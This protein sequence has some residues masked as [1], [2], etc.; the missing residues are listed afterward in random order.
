M[1]SG[2]YAINICAALNYNLVYMACHYL[3]GAYSVQEMP[4]LRC[5]VKRCQQ[6]ILKRN[7][8]RRNKLDYSRIRLNRLLL[9]YIYFFIT[10]RCLK[11]MPRLLLLLLLEAQN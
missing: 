5:Y 9:L 11:S 10:D 8:R 7:K 3:E 1:P 6:E 4:T 2:D